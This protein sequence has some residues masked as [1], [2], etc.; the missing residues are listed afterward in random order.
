[1]YMKYNLIEM[2]M[3]KNAQWIIS[4]D[5]YHVGKKGAYIHQTIH[6]KSKVK[7]YARLIVSTCI[8]II[9]YPDKNHELFL[10]SMIHIVNKMI[11]GY[12]F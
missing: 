11:K 8:D 10:F 6:K 12:K 5:E 9:I 3:E 4:S 2:G 7:M 1:M